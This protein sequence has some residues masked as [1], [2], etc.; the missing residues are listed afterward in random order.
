MRNPTDD[1][2][3]DYADDLDEDA[4]WALWEAHHGRLRPEGAIKHNGVWRPVQTTEP[5][6]GLL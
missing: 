4:L 6:E 3:P 1:D 2:G 5:R